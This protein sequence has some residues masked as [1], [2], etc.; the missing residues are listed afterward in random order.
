MPS[1]FDTFLHTENI[2][3][4]EAK[5]RLESDPGRLA[6]LKAMLA[7]EKARI[8]VPDDRIVRHLQ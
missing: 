7:R 2:K 4:F 6:A 3:N 1:R 8:P 5:I